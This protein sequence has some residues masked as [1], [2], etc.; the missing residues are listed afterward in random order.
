LE[1]VETGQERED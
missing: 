1:K